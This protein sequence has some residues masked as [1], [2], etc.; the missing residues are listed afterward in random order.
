MARFEL[1]LTGMCCKPG[2]SPQPGDRGSKSLGTL[3]LNTTG[4]QVSSLS[5]LDKQRTQC[6]MARAMV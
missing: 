4:Q 2:V 6:V 5:Y 3:A 1:T